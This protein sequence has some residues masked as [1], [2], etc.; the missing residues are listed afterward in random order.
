LPIN[1]S[2]AQSTDAGWVISGTPTEIV[3]IPLPDAEQGNPSISGEILANEGD[4]GVLVVASGAS[5]TFSAVSDRE[6]HYTIFNVGSGDY[7]VR[8]YAAGLQLN[9]EQVTMAD[10]PLE[11]VDLSVSEDGLATLSGSVSIVNAP[12]GAMT[13]VVLVVD[14]TFDENFARGEVPPGLRAPQT[15]EP[16]VTGS[17]TIEGVPAGDY[18][19]LAAFENDDLVRDPDQNIA[20]THIVRVTID[21]NAGDVDLSESFK[22]TEALEVISPG[23]DR[24]EQVSSAPTLEW[25]DDSSEE[26]YT[27]EVYNAYGD[28]VWDNGGQNVPRVTG[29]GGTVTVDYTGPTESGMYYQFRAK[30][31]KSGSPISATEDLRGVFFFE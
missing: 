23:K 13:S 29:G 15:G 26:H 2:T 24:P 16:N 5:G 31:W 4:E 10:D 7:E 17:W 27:V 6:G 22:I 21:P 19:V 3:L 8:G 30:S 9:P 28:M 1:T 11:D 18:V 12:G 14:S 20:G 25:V